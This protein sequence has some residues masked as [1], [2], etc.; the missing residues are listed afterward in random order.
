L[1]VRDDVVRVRAD[2]DNQIEQFWATTKKRYKEPPPPV[3]EFYNARVV[4]ADRL[5]N[6]LSG[7]RFRV[8]DTTTVP[9][10][11]PL[12]VL[13]AA[14]VEGC[15]ASFAR[16]QST[17]VQMSWDVKIFG[18]GLTPSGSLQVLTEAV[19]SA[20]SGEAKVVFV[21]GS[22][23]VEK[24]TA[25]KRG[26]VIGH[27]YRIDGSK[28]KPDSEPGLFVLDPSTL[29]P[30]A[31]V[32]K[33]YPLAGDTT[34]A[35]ATYKYSD[36]LSGGIGLQLGITAFGADI[37]LKGE[38]KRSASV[39]LTYQLKG[40]HDYELRRFAEGDGLVWRTVTA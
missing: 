40:G 31:D 24:V 11:I 12:F 29:L 38:I 19:F 8:D 15:S 7:R 30:A 6:F 22:L 35:L 2:L 25:L 9:I 13:S 3:A 23:R 14:A 39:E 28:M 18:T 17:V 4:A 1:D 21:P 34:G 36:K 16:Q 26:R 37:K 33:T 27:G 10:Q 20:K 5:R 32:V